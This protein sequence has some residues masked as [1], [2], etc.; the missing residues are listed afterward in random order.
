MTTIYRS[1]LEDQYIRVRVR[2]KE[3]GVI[4]DPTSDV[5][6]L[7]AIVD[8]DGNEPISGDWATGEWETD[9]NANAYYARALMSTIFVSSPPFTAGQYRVWCRIQDNPELV[10]EPVYTLVVY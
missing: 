3:A 6:D 9:A 1:S 7:A 4:L 5:V 10:V 2:A 8:T